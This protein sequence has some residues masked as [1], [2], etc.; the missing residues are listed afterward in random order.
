ME[1]GAKIMTVGDVLFYY[2]LDVRGNNS[3]SNISGLLTCPSTHFECNN[4]HCINLRWL[5]DGDDDCGDNSDEDIDGH[6]RE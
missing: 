1:C 6:C 4:R 3:A 2:L 5:C